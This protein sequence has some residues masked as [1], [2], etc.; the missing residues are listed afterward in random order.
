MP[1]DLIT[2][3][4]EKV[5]LL[6]AAIYQLG[7]RGRAAA[8]AEQDYRIGLRKKI[9]EEREKGT[10]VTIIGDLCRGDPEIAKLRFR[11]DCAQVVYQSALEA[12]N[13]YKLQL[14]LMDAQ[15]T[16]EWNNA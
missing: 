14:R 11:R 1:D 2:A 12:I 5:A 10:P 4:G 6:D 15:I 16:R 9:L 3:L 7:K 13:S 8:E